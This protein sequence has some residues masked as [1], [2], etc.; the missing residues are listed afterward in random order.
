MPRIDSR[1]L[2]ESVQEVENEYHSVN[3][4]PAKAMTKVWHLSGAVIPD[5]PQR[6]FVTKRTYTV[7]RVSVNHGLSVSAIASLLNRS[8][9]E[10]DKM[11]R[12][13]KCNEL[14][15]T[16]RGYKHDREKY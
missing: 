2:L 3:I 4:A 12:A 1:M 6:V 9:S 8:P 16:K 15:I 11:V 5:D 7:I 14:K 13:Y 10:I